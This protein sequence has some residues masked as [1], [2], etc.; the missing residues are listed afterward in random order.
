MNVPLGDLVVTGARNSAW[1]A[2]AG[3]SGHHPDPPA[4]LRLRV[5]GGRYQRQF[6]EEAEAVSNRTAAYL[7][8]NHLDANDPTR[9]REQRRRS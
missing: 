9:S 2:G 6:A 4:G 7:P 8:A 3:A 5:V 1:L